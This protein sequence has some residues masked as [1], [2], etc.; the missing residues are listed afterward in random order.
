METL[1]SKAL[2]VLIFLTAIF[3]VHK[4]FYMRSF[5][6]MFLDYTNALSFRVKFTQTSSGY[7]LELY[8]SPVDNMA[9]L[10]PRF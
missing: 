3:S 10:K 1:N 6:S 9:D 8:S 4:L 7:Q 2:F 5:V